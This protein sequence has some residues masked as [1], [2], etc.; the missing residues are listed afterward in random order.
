MK[1]LYTGLLFDFKVSFHREISADSYKLVIIF[2]Q[3]SNVVIVLFVSIQFNFIW[4]W[5]KFFCRFFFFTRFLIH[6]KFIKT[7]LVILFEFNISC[8]VWK[9]FALIIQNYANFE[10]K[11]FFGIHLFTDKLFFWVNNKYISEG[12]DWAFFKYLFSTKTQ[13]Y[14]KNLFT[15]SVN[16]RKSSVISEKWPVNWTKS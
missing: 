11:M 2:R 4:V 15:I 3:L 6:F 13:I 14:C 1:K 8:E 12:N 10:L 16:I 5:L 7:F 9:K